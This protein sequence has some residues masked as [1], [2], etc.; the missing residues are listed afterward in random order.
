MYRRVVPFVLLVAGCLSSLGA[1]QAESPPA[2]QASATSGSAPQQPPGATGPALRLH[3]VG[4][5]NVGEARGFSLAI[6]CS[7]PGTQMLRYVGYRPDSFDPPIPKGQMQPIYR[8]EL[9]QA[10]K[11]QPHP[12]GWCGTGVDDIELVP[13]TSATFGVWVPAGPWEAARVG[14]AWR[15]AAGEK[16]AAPAI[17]W[18]PELTRREMRRLPPIPVV[19]DPQRPT[20]AYRAQA[21]R[22]RPG[23]RALP[24]DVHRREPAAALCEL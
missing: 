24:H 16:D 13:K 10:G 23:C 3:L 8:V 12:I 14:V 19:R 1:A 22:R 6:E 18:S 21:C 9:K 2:K 15:A 17:A 11:W 5:Q 20:K 4:R 7:N